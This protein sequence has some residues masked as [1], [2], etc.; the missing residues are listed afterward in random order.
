MEI[1]PQ[2]HT[3]KQYAVYCFADIPGG[4]LFPY[5]L[6]FSHILPNSPIKSRHQPYSQRMRRKKKLPSFRQQPLRALL[7]SHFFQRAFADQD[8]FFAVGGQRYPQR[9]IAV[10]DRFCGGGEFGFDRQCSRFFAGVFE[11]FG[12][13]IHTHPQ[14]DTGFGGD[15][16]HFVPECL[17]DRINERLCRTAKE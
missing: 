8:T 12:L 16:S 10:F 3:G 6:I 13:F 5:S 4:K 2:H 14:G 11:S 17:L 15:I 9:Y 1:A 7:F